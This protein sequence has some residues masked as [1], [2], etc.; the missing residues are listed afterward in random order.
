MYLQSHLGVEDIC[1]TDLVAQN[2]IIAEA[3]LINLNC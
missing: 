2:T 3:P 1:T